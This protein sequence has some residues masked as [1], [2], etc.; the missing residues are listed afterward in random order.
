MMLSGERFLAVRLTAA[1]RASLREL[2]G[3]LAP[4]AVVP[5]T[6]G[7]VAICPG[8][9]ALVDGRDQVTLVGT[10]TEFRAAGVF[11][12]AER[13]ALTARIS[14][15]GRAGS[16]L[17]AYLLL[18]SLL[19]AADRKLAVALGALSMVLI[20][21]TAVLRLTYV[22]GGGRHISLLDAAYFAVETV[23]TVGYGDYSFRGQSP[24]LIVFAIVLMLAGALFVAVFFAL[25]TNVLVSRRIEEA[26]GRQRITGLDGHVLV[27]GLGTIGL[28]VVQQMVATGSDV[29]VVEKNE[30]N[31]HLAQ[32][33]ALG[34]PVVIADATLPEVLRS[35]RLATAAAVAVLTS[36]DLVNLETGL[37]IR[38]QLG[39]RRE[40]TPVVL[41]IFDPQLARSVQE[42]F[43]FTDVRST[44]ALAA[45]WFVGAALG[46]EVLSTFYAAGVPLLVARLTVSPGGGLDGLTMLDLAARSR[47]LAIR[48][49]ADPMVLEHPLRRETRFGA[50]DEAYLI[51]PYEELL[52][53]L[54][55][56]RLSP[57]SPARLPAE[58]CLRSD[59]VI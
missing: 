31:R 43:G 49:V 58:P 54:R 32:L 9:D 7:E 34:V 45:P 3:S 33:R 20:G 2:Y 39:A 48:R 14:R 41:R 47:V 50:A 53:V 18:L 10:P 13:A 59:C 55:R 29:V 11:D 16:P 52:S 15:S 37:A 35:V 26:L 30:H 12:H 51:G 8:R 27:V 25:V 5:A 17:R 44:A 46:L 57:Q 56:D 42:T 21:A 1:G 6:D 28:R 36:D 4:I 19:Q 24:W 23:T 38:D 22:E 40:S